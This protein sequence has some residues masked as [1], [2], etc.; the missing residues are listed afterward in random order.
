MDYDEWVV[1]TD[2][3]HVKID[4]TSYYLRT[5]ADT[6]YL[7]DVSYQKYTDEDFENALAAKQN[8]RDTVDN[9]L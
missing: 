8:E 4:M 2:T 6:L 7:V 3:Y 5:S 1:D 9:D